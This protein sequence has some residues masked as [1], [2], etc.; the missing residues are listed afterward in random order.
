MMLDKDP[1]HPV[2]TLEPDLTWKVWRGVRF[3]ARPVT[4]TGTAEEVAE[5]VQELRDRA[6]LPAGPDHCAVYWLRVRPEGED[7]LFVDLTL[8][9]EHE[10]RQEQ[11]RPPIRQ[12]L[13]GTIRE[14]LEAQRENTLD[15][16]QGDQ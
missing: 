2:C 12:H 5:R 16:A 6:P 13:L 4:F 8:L 1:R 3:T 9:V 14:E 10:R 11:P 7:R 15:E